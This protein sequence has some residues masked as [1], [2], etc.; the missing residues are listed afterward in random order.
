MNR[1]PPPKEP[2]TVERVAEWMLEEL[3]LRDGFLSEDV[4]TIEIV[5]LFGGDFCGQDADG[6]FFIT[7]PLRDAFERLA[8]LSPRRI[9]WDDAARA[10][11]LGALPADPYR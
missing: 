1:A 8:L 4:A 6:S 10:W 11:R 5:R 9:L 2:V 7:Q 3:I